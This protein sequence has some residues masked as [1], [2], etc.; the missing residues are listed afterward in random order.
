MRF[1]KKL[2]IYFLLAILFSCSSSERREQETT[3]ITYNNFINKLSFKDS[4]D[5]ALYKITNDNF[6]KDK[7]LVSYLNGGMSSAKIFLLEVDKKKYVLRTL[8]LKYDMKR[9]EEEIKIHSFA[10]SIG[11]SPPLI[12][13]DDKL[14]FI[15]M[16]Y[17]D[18]YT[19]SNYKSNI[20]KDT[21]DKINER[22]VNRIAV[23]LAK[24]HDYKGDYE[25]NRPQIWRAKKHY[26]RAKKR[27]NAFPSIYENLYREYYQEGYEAN[28]NYRDDLVL[29][30]GDLNPSNII[31]AKN[32]SI[33][34]LDWTSA[35]WDNKYTDLGYFSFLNGVSKEQSKMFLSSYLGQEANEEQFKKLQRAQKRT[36]FLTSTVWFDFAESNDDKSIAISNRVKELDILVENS[37]LKT[38]REYIENNEIVSLKSADKKAIK[39]YALGFLK[40]Y[41]ALD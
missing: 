23:M 38:G 21:N 6:A 35:T 26:E 40:T 36:S 8:N 13:I 22:I 27:G 39:L 2:F 19:L 25:Q 17:I 24:L 29:C 16:P 15:I 34:L 32:G 3:K 10:A 11:I 5:S 4:F 14:E 28:L 12:Y 30:H 20:S 31:I 9:R 1:I 33:Y 7:L 41:L 18:G 37:N